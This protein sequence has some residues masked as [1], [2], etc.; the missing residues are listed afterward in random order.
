MDLSIPVQTKSL[1]IVSAKINIYELVLNQG[2]KC[3]VYQFDSQGVMIQSKEV[4]IVGDEY[5][6]WISDQDMT[7]LILSK[8]GL[9]PL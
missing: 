8:I 3:V 9:V 1:D 6:S 5:N 7:I 4:E 2:F